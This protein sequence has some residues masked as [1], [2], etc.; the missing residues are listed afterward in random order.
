MVQEEAL[1]LRVF[2][3]P[4]GG[5]RAVEFNIPLTTYNFVSF[6]FYIQPDFNTRFT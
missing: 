4:V 6:G 5:S 3:S 2:D 1:F